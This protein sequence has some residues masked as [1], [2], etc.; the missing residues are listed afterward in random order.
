M[1]RVR[2]DETQ[3]RWNNHDRKRGLIRVSDGMIVNVI[4]E[5]V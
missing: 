5:R 3:T 1:E 2:V 4:M